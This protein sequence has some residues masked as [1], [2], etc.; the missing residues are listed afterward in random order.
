L[1]RYSARPIELEAGTRAS[2]NEDR[3]LAISTVPLLTAAGASD[4]GIASGPMNLIFMVPFDVF[5]T[6]LMKRRTQLTPGGISGTKLT[7]DNSSVFSWGASVFR[8]MAMNT[9][10]NTRTTNNMMT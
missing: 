2:Q 7:S 6:L 1:G 3:A 9:E 4:E 5:S 10:A 8:K